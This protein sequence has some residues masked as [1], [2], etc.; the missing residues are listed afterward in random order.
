MIHAP[1]NN[2]RA[3]KIEQARGAL[4]QLAAAVARPGYYGT[5]TLT[6][7]LQDGHVQQVKIATERL[8]K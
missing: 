8:V 6:F 2:E 1:A 3:T 4:D 7:S 5:A